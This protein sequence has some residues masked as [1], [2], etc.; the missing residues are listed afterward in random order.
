MRERGIDVRETVRE[1][2]TTDVKAVNLVSAV[3][4]EAADTKFETRRR[5]SW[6]ALWSPANP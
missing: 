4:R 5:M 2:F 6:N 1:Q 3:A